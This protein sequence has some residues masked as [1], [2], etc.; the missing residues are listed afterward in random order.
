MKRTEPTAGDLKIQLNKSS[1]EIQFLT[2]ALGRRRLGNKL[3]SQ[4]GGNRDLYE[5][6][7]YKKDL[8]F[9]DFYTQYS[10]Q[11][12]ASAIID[13]PVDG[14]WRGPIGIMESNDD[15]TTPLEA[16]WPILERGLQ[17]KSQL[18][19]LDKLVGI[20]S[21]A[22]LF[23]GFSDIKGNGDLA[24]PI[25]NGGN[26]KLLYVRP[27]SQ[28]NATIQSYVTSPSDER[29]GQPLLYSLTVHQSGTASSQTFSVHY[30]RVLHVA[31]G[32]LEGTLVGTSRL[33]VVFNRLQD[34]EKLVGGSAEMFWRGARPGYYG[35]IS[36]D[37]VMSPEEQDKL[38][39]QLDEYDHN[40]RRFLISSGV[41]MESLAQQVADP[42]SHVSV[43]IEMISAQ[44][45][46]PKRILTG[47]ERGELAS[48]E[49]KNSWL[50][51]LQSRREEWI[52]PFILHPLIEK[53]IEYGIL[54][55]ALPG[56]YTIEWSDL[57]SP[58]EKEKTEI[59]QQRASAVQS[60]AANPYSMDILPPKAFY[61]WCLGLSEEEVELIIEMQKAQMEEDDQEEDEVIEEEEI[62]DI[63]SK[64]DEEEE[65][66]K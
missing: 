23:L 45:G 13:R 60:Y 4:Y 53:C 35:S 29:Y 38:K 2:E 6:L 14:S 50:E 59:G 17:L 63:D 30:S 9:M 16:A 43:Q 40:L 46:I 37:V 64:E 27:L 36:P 34:I 39:D 12:I 66:E 31:D 49:D 20:G 25:K 19:R 56:G 58:S 65:E 61:K 3:G 51:I 21:Y 44:T 33:K 32:L 7:G 28:N 15:M 57:W 24:Q 55:K 1:Q 10:R 52:E 11:D 42:A 41:N 22:C 48:T 62:S 8:T 54:P 18:Q 26:L 5:T 47:S